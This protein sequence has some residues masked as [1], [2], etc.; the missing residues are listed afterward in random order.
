MVGAT[1]VQAEADS[2]G[3]RAQPMLLTGTWQYSARQ[4]VR[5]GQ[6]ADGDPGR[7][8]WQP[9]SSPAPQSLWS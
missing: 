6:Q 8:A 5:G 2:G 7:G 1:A 9:R 3:W 4:Q